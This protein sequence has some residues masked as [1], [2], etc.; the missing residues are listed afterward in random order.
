MSI[1]SKKKSSTVDLNNVAEDF[2]AQGI[3]STNTFCSKSCLNMFQYSEEEFMNEKWDRVFCEYL[4]FY[5]AQ[6]S[7]MLI[8][9][10]TPALEVAKIRD[11]I[12]TIVQS[13]IFENLTKDGYSQNDVDTLNKSFDRCFGLRD[14]QYSLCQEIM[15]KQEDEFYLKSEVRQESSGK[16][17]II[18]QQRFSNIFQTMAHGWT[19]DIKDFTI[20]NKDSSITIYSR[21]SMLQTFIDILGSITVGTTA[22]IAIATMVTGMYGESLHNSPMFA[23]RDALINSKKAVHKQ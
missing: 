16:V 5:I 18:S 7:R 21:G 23:F 15:L 12:N 10:K 8:N 17:R 4:Y 9:N 11:N 6:F 20:I 14:I 1:F 3:A 13:I 19:P 22:D 2:C